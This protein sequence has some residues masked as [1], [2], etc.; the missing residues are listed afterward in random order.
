MKREAPVVGSL[1]LFLAMA[2]ATP[3]VARQIET[4]FEITRDGLQAVHTD[5]ERREPEVIS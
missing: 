3:P 4:T 1:F 5:S 2:C